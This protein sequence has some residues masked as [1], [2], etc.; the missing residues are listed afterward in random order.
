L[1]RRCR[2]NDVTVEKMRLG[3]FIR[4]LTFSVKTI[5]DFGC[6]GSRATTVST[7]LSPPYGVAHAVFLPI[8]I[9]KCGGIQTIYY[10]T[11]TS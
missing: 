9:Q 11:T 8:I 10:F 5:I 4:T 7:L 3:E 6:V 2:S 1:R